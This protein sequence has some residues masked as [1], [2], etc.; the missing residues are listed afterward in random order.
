MR[1]CE[2]RARAGWSSLIAV[3]PV[4]R[5]RV[6]LATPLMV[7]LARV[8]PAESLRSVLIGQ[9]MHVEHMVTW[10]AVTFGASQA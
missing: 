3:E 10:D 5:V 2:E 7:C 9:G 8:V 1:R 6:E 4:D